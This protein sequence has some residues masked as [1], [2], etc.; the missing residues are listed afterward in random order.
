MKVL[1]R[2]APFLGVGLLAYLLDNGENQRP[3]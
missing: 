2:L 3:G 1:L